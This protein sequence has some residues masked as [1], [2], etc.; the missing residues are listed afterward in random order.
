VASGFDG[1]GP[2][3]PRAIVLAGGRGARLAPFTSVLPKPLMPV[4]NR[5]ILELVIDQ[6]VDHGI[7]DITLSVGYL[8]HLIRAVLDNGGRNPRARIRYVHEDQPLGT[9]GPLRLVRGLSDTFLVM[10]GDILTTL[11]YGELVEHHR[12]QGNAV[13]IAT[14]RRTVKIDYG[15]LDSYPDGDGA[16]VVAYTEKPELSMVVSMG[17]YVL[18]PRVASY[19]P[20]GEHFDFPEL[21]QALLDAGEPVGSFEYDGLWF[22]IGR[23]EDYERAVGIWNAEEDD[24][25]PSDVADADAVSVSL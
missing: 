12:R 24:G 6:L 9:A 4:G 14:H 7:R 20:E 8:S 3:P 17:I 1:A 18:E 19:V 25:V 2:A 10:N 15:V 16:K 5:S 21:V 11:D 22:D 13:T 23:R